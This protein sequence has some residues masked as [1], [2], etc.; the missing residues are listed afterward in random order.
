MI[1]PICARTQEGSQAL[2]E[3]IK[4]RAFMAEEIALPLKRCEILDIWYL[5]LEQWPALHATT[6]AVL[7]WSAMMGCGV[8]HCMHDGRAIPEIDT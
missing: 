2:L 7:L 4:A 8:H 3:A 5:R 1:I 6:A